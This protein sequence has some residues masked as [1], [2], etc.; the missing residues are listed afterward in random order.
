MTIYIP[1]AKVEWPNLLRVG[2]KCYS[3]GLLLNAFPTF[4]DAT[5]YVGPTAVNG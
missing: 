2:H 5:H 4:A 1:A 3:A